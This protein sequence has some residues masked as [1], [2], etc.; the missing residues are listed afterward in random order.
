MV[1]DRNAL[2]VKLV[3]LLLFAGLLWSS[4]SAVGTWAVVT[5]PDSVQPGELLTLVFSLEGSGVCG[6]SGTVSYDRELLT[7]EDGVFLGPEGWRLDIRGDRFLAYDESLEAPITEHTSLICFTF[8]VAADL[9]EGTQ[10]QVCCRDLV[11]TD[12]AGDIMVDTAVYSASIPVSETVS[13]ATEEPT[14]T[15]APTQITEPE[16]T[17]PEITEPLE[18]APVN[19]AEPSNP[20]QTERQEVTL[21]Q[22][23]EPSIQQQDTV[24]TTPATSM[25]EQQDSGRMILPA[26]VL[27]IASGI[28]L[29]L[30]FVRKKHGD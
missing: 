21:P 1:S 25:D 28:V 20:A 23:T 3:C 8:S 10:I 4:V 27:C 30:G 9:P 17:E 26:A 14:E 16:I 11:I 6:V 2:R 24:P 5:G 22:R 12:G 7:L 29:L 13:E 19:T 18:T 15:S